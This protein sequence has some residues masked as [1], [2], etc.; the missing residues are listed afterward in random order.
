[1]KN[2]VFASCIFIIFVI[3]RQI[4]S[5]YV[6]REE[7]MGESA[8]LLTGKLENVWKKTTANLWRKD[9]VDDL[10]KNIFE[11][12]MT[13]D[14]MKEGNADEWKEEALNLSRKETPDNLMEETKNIL[15]EET[16]ISLAEETPDDLEE[17]IADARKREAVD[18]LEKEAAVVSVKEILNALKK[19]AAAE[20]KKKQTRVTMNSTHYYLEGEKGRKHRVPLFGSVSANILMLENVSKVSKYVHYFSYSIVILQ[21]YGEIS[22]KL[23]SCDSV[24]GNVSLFTTLPFSRP[25]GTNPIFSEKSGNFVFVITT[26]V[27]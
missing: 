5:E 7:T 8:G 26:N 18:L 22:E 11:E 19:C 27:F 3:P 15:K 14:T 4:R 25:N 9:T 20:L 12:P 10:K 6:S 21:S 23:P 1:M 13:P 2:I 16:M 24:P 17:A